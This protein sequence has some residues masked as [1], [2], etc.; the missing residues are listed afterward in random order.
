MKSSCWYHLHKLQED[1]I[2]CLEQRIKGN[3]VPAASLKSIYENRL[4]NMKSAVL[5]WKNRGRV[6][7]FNISLA[8]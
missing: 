7:I 5:L 2:E 3:E 6:C 4:S 1:K 8:G